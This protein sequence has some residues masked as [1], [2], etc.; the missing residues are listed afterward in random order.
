MNKMNIFQYLNLSNEEENDDKTN[1]NVIED[2]ESQNLPLLPIQE[3]QNFF[4]FSQ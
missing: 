3:D 1:N 2:T 4:L